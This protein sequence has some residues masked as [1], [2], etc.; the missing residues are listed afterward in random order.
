[1]Q[2]RHKEGHPVHVLMRIAPFAIPAVPSSE[3]Q[4]A[5]TNRNS[6]RTAISIP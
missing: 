3:S 5:S 6:H 1:M 4:K 2:L